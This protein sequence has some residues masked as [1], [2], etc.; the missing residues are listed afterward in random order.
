MDSR[1]IERFLEGNLVLDCPKIRLTPCVNE[2]GQDVLN[3]AG[4]ISATEPGRFLLKVFFEQ[5]FAFE[6]TFERLNWKAGR[7]ID[8]KHYYDLEAV[9]IGGNLWKS[10]KILPDRTSGSAGSMIV[11]GFDELEHIDVGH[12]NIKGSSAQFYFNDSIKAPFNTVIKEEK[13]VGGKQRSFSSKLALARFESDGVSL[14]IDNSSGKTI[15]RAKF[16]ATDIPRAT[17]NR[18]YEAFSFALAYPKS[19]SILVLLDAKIRTTVLRAVEPMQIKTR[20]GPPLKIFDE[21]ATSFVWELFT[22]Y[23]SYVAT[24]EASNCHQLSLWVKSVLEAGQATLSVQA[25]TLSVVVESLLIEQMENLYQ[26]SDELI[27]NIQKAEKVIKDDSDLDAGFRQRVLGALN[28]MRKPRAKDVLKEL[29]T[30]TLID[31][32]LVKIYG[33]LRNKMAHGASSPHADI[34]A[35]LNETNAVLV[36]FYQLIFLTIDYQGR[37]SDYGEHGF[38]VR[39]FN[40]KLA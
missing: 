4:V 14:E 40:K 23:Y 18:V 19:W 20:T 12:E 31:R 22:K 35:L 16:V 8:D 10:K 24:D 9:D 17:I 29:E 34:Q 36:L 39:E 3:G 11:A 26:L 38:P 28:S 7:I 25:L 2:H 1:D 6:E 13:E 5:P 15:L 32:Q 37:F 30:R 33:K 27:E 21:Y